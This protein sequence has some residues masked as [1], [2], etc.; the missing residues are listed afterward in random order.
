MPDFSH[1]A[2]LDFTDLYGG[3]CH[4][5]ARH[6]LLVV[7]MLYSSILPFVA[8]PKA[9]RAI[10]PTPGWIASQDV[11]NKCVPPTLCIVWT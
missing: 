11:L 3:Q 6:F 7:S 2:I 9:S 10:A 5:P 1:V 4:E 8:Q